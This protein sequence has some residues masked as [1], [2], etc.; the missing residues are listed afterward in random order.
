MYKTF[1]TFTPNIGGMNILFSDGVGQK[2]FITRSQMEFIS[3]GTVFIQI[4][5]T[6]KQ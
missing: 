2:Y 6:I 3:D 5:H 1:C 4:T